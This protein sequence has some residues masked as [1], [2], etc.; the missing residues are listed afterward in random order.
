MSKIRQDGSGA[1]TVAIAALGWIAGDAELLASFL[2]ASGVRPEDLRR[3]AG[4]PEFLAAVLDFLLLDDAWVI[5][6]CD[7]AGLGYDRVRQARAALPGAA[8]DWG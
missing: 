2:G 7:A 6:F 1:E 3:R 8:P 5:A 4:E